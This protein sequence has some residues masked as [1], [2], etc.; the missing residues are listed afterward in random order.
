M[1]E[2]VE[3]TVDRG[4]SPLTERSLSIIIACYRDA[5]SVR[6]FCRQLSEILPQITPNYEIIYVNDAS[7]DD[8]CKILAE[9][10][11]R[12]PR[13]VGRTVSLPVKTEFHSVIKVVLANPTKNARITIESRR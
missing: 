3:S 7:P 12:D 5:G 11:A 6:E 13:L 4:D 9:I 2:R 1:E 8:A 10:A